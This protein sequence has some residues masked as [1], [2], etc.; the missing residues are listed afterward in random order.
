MKFSITDF[1]S[2]C[3]PADLVTFTEEIRNRKLHFLCSDVAIINNKVWKSNQTKNQGYLTGRNSRWKKK[4]WSRE[5]YF[6]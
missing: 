5:F 3:D 4:F 6:A 2:K 1:F